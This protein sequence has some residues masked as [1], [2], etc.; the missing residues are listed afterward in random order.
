VA[1]GSF[2]LD[3]ETHLPPSDCPAPLAAFAVWLGSVSVSPPSPSSA[4]PPPPSCGTLA[5]KLFRGEQAISRFV[6]H[7]TPNHTSSHTFVTV[8][9]SRLPHV[10][11][12]FHAAHG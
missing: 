6:W 3:D 1:L 10:L 4:L 11:P 9:G 2:P 12:C 8:M 5:L 7:F